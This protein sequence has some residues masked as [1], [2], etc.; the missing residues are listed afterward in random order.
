M[1]LASNLPLGYGNIKKKCLHS[2]LWVLKLKR[3]A[4]TMHIQG[5]VTV[6][7]KGAPPPAI[8]T[9]HAIAP[10]SSQSWSQTVRSIRWMKESPPTSLCD[11]VFWQRD[12]PLSEFTDQLL[13]PLIYKS[14]VACPIYRKESSDRFLLS[15]DRCTLIEICLVPVWS[16]YCQL[17]GG[18]DFTNVTSAWT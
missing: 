18:G 8:Y 4:V 6:S 10:L 1:I 12:L 17:R 16:M 9:Y 5:Q 7:C 11:T 3:D 14:L 15:R 2:K 13:Q